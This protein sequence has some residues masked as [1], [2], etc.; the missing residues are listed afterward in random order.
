M[1]KSLSLKLAMQNLR[2]SYRLSVPYILAGILSFA[3][4]Y[5]VLALSDDPGL[6][7]SFGGR[8]ARQMLGFGSYITAIGAFLFLFNIN[9]YLIRQRGREFALYGVLGMDKMNVMKVLLLETLI[10]F[11]IVAA[12]GIVSGIVFGKLFQLILIRMIA[13]KNN[14]AMSINVTQILNTMFLFGIIYLANLVYASLKVAVSSPVS[15]LQEKNAGER[16]SKGTAGIA[17]LGIV[18]ILAGYFLAQLVDDL[19]VAVTR[20]LPAV[21]LV[22]IGTHCLFLAGSSVFLSFLKKNRK[23]YYQPHHFI[24][25]SGLMHRMKRNA[26]G[27]ATVCILACMVIITVSV[28]AAIYFGTAG[29]MDST[30]PNEI[31]LYGQVNQKKY[32][33]LF[34]DAFTESAER[35][36]GTNLRTIYS[37]CVTYTEENGVFMQGEFTE[38]NTYITFMRQDDV[39]SLLKTNIQLQDGEVYIRSN[40]KKQYPETITIN[41][42]SLKVAGQEK[43]DSQIITGVWGYQDFNNLLVVVPE[44]TDTLYD[45][46]DSDIRQMFMFGYDPATDDPDEIADA[47]N[48]AYHA[49]SDSN[50]YR[51]DYDDFGG[52]I[53]SVSRT[54]EFTETMSAYGSLMFLGVFLG[55]MFL[56]MTVLIIYYKQ[57]SEGYEDIERFRAM[58][59]V[60]LDEDEVRKTINSQVLITFFAP[61]I[62]AIIHVIFAHKMVGTIVDGFGTIDPNVYTMT[63][64]AVSLIFVVIYMIVYWGTSTVYYHII[65]QA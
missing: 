62:T 34:R 5:I 25:I 37:A 23:Y 51:P 6:A 27:L 47:L 2:S 56:I 21:V 17:V 11:A 44:I 24:S 45:E 64:A 54:V 36:A 53:N 60:G 28:T 3:M 35:H 42:V 14:I 4:C 57:L 29:S 32:Y 9:R 38:T 59:N 58:E 15:L 40:V 55:T 1:R 65:R 61:L 20:F 43:G 16:Q 19:R 7:A 22:I 26:S 30:Y 8:T 63:L 39:N 46:E 50:K 48:D 13:M 33:D 18:C 49:V 31:V 12:G 41:G 10:T 52:Y